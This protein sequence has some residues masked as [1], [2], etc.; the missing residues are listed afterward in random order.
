MKYGFVYIWYDRK[1]KRYYVGAHWGTENDG[2][3]C[4]SPWMK[5]AFNKRPA[6]FTRRILARIY[7]NRQ[8]MF[9][10]EAR[11]QS[12]IKDDELKVRYY[13]IKRHGDRHWSTDEQRALTVKEKIKAADN[14]RGL[15]AYAT[16][17][18]GTKRTEEFKQKISNTL[19]GRPLGYE[20]S[21]ETRA[22]ISENVKR[23]QAEGKVGMRGKQHKA[24]TKE[25]MS[26]NNAMNNPMYR[27]KIGEANRGKVGLW[28]NSQKKM[29]KPGTE[30]YDSLLAIGYKPKEELV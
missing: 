30:L 13:N 26:A 3:I 18:K 29:A 2:Y 4:S 22:K 19:K 28:L 14:T 21:A 11:W 15:R 5:Q 12:L 9:N 7:T 23:L 25:K 8:D 6:D 17:I 1:H 20:R 16:K 27:A 24:E 10:E